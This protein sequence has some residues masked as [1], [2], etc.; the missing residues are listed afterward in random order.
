MAERMCSW[1]LPRLGTGLPL[2]TVAV[3]VRC[4]PYTA[5]LALHVLRSYFTDEKTK[6]QHGPS[7]AL[8]TASQEFAL[9]C[10]V[11]HHRGLQ[12]SGQLCFYI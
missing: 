6:S 5:S 8:G 9:G 10:A 3:K 11:A 12:K 2:C 4:P 7:P 1:Q